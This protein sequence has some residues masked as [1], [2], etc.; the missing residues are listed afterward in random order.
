[1]ISRVVVW[2]KE[3]L[4]DRTQR[5][6]VGGKPSKEASVTS[7]VP[8]GSV[9]GTLLF[10]EYVHG[11]W[12]NIDSSI[13]LFADDC[14]IYRKITNKNDIENF[15]KDLD[16]LWEWAV[17]NGMKINPGKSKAITFTRARVKI[18]PGYC[19]G[20]QKIPEA[21]SCKYLA[22]ILTK[23]FKLGGPI[24]LHSAKSLE[25]TSLCNARSQK[26]KQEYKKLSLHVIGTS[27]S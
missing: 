10:L 19:L 3:F 14:V 4:V 22:I 1:M 25:G 12:R 6:R 15:Q 16:T 11:I 5:V 2:V 23:R 13:T 20:D 26:R 24:K 9:L 21:S 17:E 27:C 18:P 8:K 7:R